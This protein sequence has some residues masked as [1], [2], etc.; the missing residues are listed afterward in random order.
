MDTLRVEVALWALEGVG[1]WQKPL[2]LAREGLYS[3][4][5]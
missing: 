1:D 2:T 3:A 5:Q 4:V